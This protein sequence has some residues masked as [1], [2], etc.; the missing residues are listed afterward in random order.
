MKLG[1]VRKFNHFLM[2]YRKRVLQFLNRGIFRRFTSHS[3]QKH[4]KISHILVS[5]VAL[6]RLYLYNECLSLQHDNRA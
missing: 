4:S 2:Y 6:I 3:E 5:I 1:V